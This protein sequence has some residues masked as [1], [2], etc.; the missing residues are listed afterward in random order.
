MRAVSG[1]FV[2]MFFGFFTWCVLKFHFFQYDDFDLAIHDQ[3][4]WNI[5]QAASTIR[6]W[7]LIFWAITP[8]LFHS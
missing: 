1:L 5:L 2:S 4:I 6:S 8:I 3:I 7:A